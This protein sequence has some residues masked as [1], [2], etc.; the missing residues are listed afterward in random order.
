MQSA[1]TRDGFDLSPCIII[2][3]KSAPGFII[4]MLLRFKSNLPYALFAF[5]QIIHNNPNMI[6]V[7]RHRIRALVGGNF[8]PRFVDLYTGFCIP[9]M[10]DASI[11]V[12]V[13]SIVSTSQ[14]LFA[15]N[16]LF[17]VGECLSS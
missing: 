15:S 5:A 11:I 10:H 13:S 17:F 6:E 16:F 9:K 3:I 14:R 2:E 1:V 7:P 8:E 4:C 12:G